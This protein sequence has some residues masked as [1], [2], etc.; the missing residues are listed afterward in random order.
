VVW[1]A[2]RGVRPV[3]GE[4]GEWVTEPVIDLVPGGEVVDA[5]VTEA[6]VKSRPVENGVFELIEFVEPIEGEWNVVST[7]GR[8]QLS[9]QLPEAAITNLHDHSRSAAGEVE[10]AR[11]NRRPSSVGS[12]WSEWGEASA[13]ALYDVQPLSV[14]PAARDPWAPIA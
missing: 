5:W 1:G 3:V 7:R 2:L 10:P 9:T 6:D 12:W 11:E 8:V 14:R 13:R 4:P